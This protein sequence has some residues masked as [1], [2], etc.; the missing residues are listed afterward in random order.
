MYI[1]M[2]IPVR[3]GHDI[4]TSDG[5]PHIWLVGESLHGIKLIAL[6][7]NGPVD[8]LSH[9]FQFLM[10]IDSLWIHTCACIKHDDLKQNAF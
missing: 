9:D 2:Y 8:R 6:I 7:A 3:T 1:N 10:D 4:P 5:I